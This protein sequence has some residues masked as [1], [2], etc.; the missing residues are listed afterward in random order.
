[1]GCQRYVVRCGTTR[2]SD[3]DLQA[4]MG[5]TAK[6]VTWSTPDAPS[7][8][9]YTITRRRS[10]RFKAVRSVSRRSDVARYVRS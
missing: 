8:D 6:S 2:T 4:L 5:V 9:D 10:D 1:M 3:P 7:V